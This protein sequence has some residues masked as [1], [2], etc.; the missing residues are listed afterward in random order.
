MKN[1]TAQVKRTDSPV[2]V[3][4]KKIIKETANVTTFILEHELGS[5]PGQFVMLWIP[6]Y[7]QKPFSIAND[8]GKQFQLT[9][10]QLGHATKQ[11]C[12]MKVGDR[13]G[14]SG[15]YGTRYT[16]EPKSHLITVG[17]GYGA[18]PLGFL[19]EEALKN[20][21]MVDFIIGART[22][23]DLIFEQR[24][25]KAGA[26]VHIST[27][28]GSKGHHGYNTEILERLLE[29][30]R[31][32]NEL[33]AVKVFACGPEV[34]QYKVAKICKEYKVPCEVSVERYMKCGFGICGNCCMDDDG[35]STCVEGTVISGEK[36]LG[37]SEF[38]K[39][40]RD[41]SGIRHDF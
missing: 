10:F 40:H 35:A 16:Y 26:E 19:A 9:I 20:K 23:K 12:K 34:M 39:Y 13:V 41:K 2:M 6:G 18:A 7:D 27:D 36:A 3:T 1:K 15:P 4:I 30:I 29:N 25:K 11:L 22:D 14:V 8:S 32:K 24:A 38:G 37:L 5:T 21:C 28:D 33:K 31:K 17:G